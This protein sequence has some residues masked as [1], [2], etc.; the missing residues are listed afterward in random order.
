MGDSPDRRSDDADEPPR[1]DWP[2]ASS[3]T[4]TPAVN[5]IRSGFQHSCHRH[6]AA[7]SGQVCG[8]VLTGVSSA[9]SMP[10]QRLRPRRVSTVC[11]VTGTGGGVP[12]RSH[13]VGGVV[14]VGYRLSGGR[15]DGEQVCRPPTDPARCCYGSV[16][17]VSE[18]LRTP[19][20]FCTVPRMAPGSSPWVDRHHPG[21][22]RAERCPPPAP[23]P[24]NRKGWLGRRRGTQV[25]RWLRPPW[26]EAGPLTGQAMPQAHR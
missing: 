3:V 4:V 10:V 15:P 5:G 18:M 2:S 22:H 7:G 1:A 21:S 26:G 14:G 24:L 23:R 12:G 9:G 16:M 8:G 13:V 25:F 19:G 6:A 17:S 20:R 11:P